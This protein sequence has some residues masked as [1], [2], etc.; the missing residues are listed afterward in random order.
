MTNPN[1]K[2][3]KETSDVVEPGEELNSVDADHKEEIQTNEDEPASTKKKLKIE[4]EDLRKKLVLLE[5][6]IDKQKAEQSKAA[7]AAGESTPAKTVI[8]M[9]SIA[10]LTQRL[11]NNKEAGEDEDDNFIRSNMH[12]FNGPAAGSSHAEKVPPVQ[13][14]NLDNK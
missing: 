2:T 3:K 9:P 10:N 14:I 4:N 5:I 12:G 13:L 11:T 8:V 7:A 6:E 1:K